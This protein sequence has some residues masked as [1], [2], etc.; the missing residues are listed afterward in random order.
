M[1][2]SKGIKNFNP[3][4]PPPSPPPSHSGEGPGV[5]SH[6]LRH[7]LGENTKRGKKKIVMTFEDYDKLNIHCSVYFADFGLPGM[8]WKYG[9]DWYNKEGRAEPPPA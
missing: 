8:W 1:P 5:G 2:G 4:L 3:I 9:V 7:A 6:S